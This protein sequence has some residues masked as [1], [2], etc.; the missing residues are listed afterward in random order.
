MFT[1]FTLSQNT[2]FF[3]YNKDKSTV[4]GAFTS[5]NNKNHEIFTTTQI[6]GD[7]VILELYEPIEDSGKATIKLGYVS[8]GFYEMDKF[9]NILKSN[10]DKVLSGWEDCSKNVN[11]PEG[12]DWC[13][14]KRAVVRI[15]ADITLIYSGVLLNQPNT[16]NP[17]PYI[18]TAFHALDRNPRDGEI[19][20]NEQS[21]CSNFVFTFGYYDEECAHSS[22]LMPLTT[23]NSSTYISSW[24]NSDFVLLKMDDTPERDDKVYY[25]GWSYYNPNNEPSPIVTCLHFPDAINQVPMQISY[26]DDEAESYNYSPFGNVYWKIQTEDG[27]CF[28]SDGSSGAPYFNEEHKVIG[29]HRAHITTALCNP[30]QYQFGGKFSESWVGGGTNATS[31]HHWLAP[32]WTSGDLSCEGYAYPIYLY[33]RLH[34][35]DLYE[36]E[37]M[38]VWDS[39]INEFVLI[40]DYFNIDEIYTGSSCRESDE[41]TVGSCIYDYTDIKAVPFLVTKGSVNDDIPVNVTIKSNKRIIMKPCT[42]IM[43]GTHF[44]ASIA[45]SN[46]EISNSDPS[47]IYVNWCCSYCNMFRQNWDTSSNHLRSNLPEPIKLQEIISII[48]N[49]ATEYIEIT[50]LGA[51]SLVHDGNIK[52]YNLLGEC[53]LLVAQTFPS[54]DSGQT[55][56]SD[57]LRIDVSGL[58]AGV[59]FVRIGDWVGRFVK[60]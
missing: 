50:G 47:N 59:Y 9:K 14:E 54:V 27:C 3:I 32:D 57:L 46:I 29:Q 26:D 30:S 48:P 49:P 43:R 13:R 55:G 33:C 38:L 22:S 18:L 10:D 28:F 37:E 8:H 20:V 39:G 23:F 16:S 1:K 21:D 36:C 42:K 5:L 41:F 15:T 4:L 52:I 25:A 31:L 17:E 53:V 58:P 7:E 2:L 24:V 40:R 35:P 6:N 11:C 51:S 44:T 45:C 60:I 19:D 34:H 12:D 56:M